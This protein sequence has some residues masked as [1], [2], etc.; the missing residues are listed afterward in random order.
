MSESIRSTDLIPQE[1]ALSKSAFPLPFLTRDDNGSFVKLL[2][3]FL[4]IYGYFKTQVQQGLEPVDGYL[5]DQTTTEVMRFQSDHFLGKDG[6]V[7]GLTWCAIAF[8]NINPNVRGALNPIANSS[9]P[10][11]LL[12]SGD[13]G[14]A[15]FV[16]QRLLLLYTSQHIPGNPMTEAGVNGCFSAN[17]KTA[18]TIF[19]KN[20]KYAKLTPDGEVGN[21]TW[22][23]LFY[24]LGQ[25]GADETVI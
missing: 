19:Q 3:R 20:Y 5:G 18:V 4:V 24:P 7:G 14:A 22:G 11:P 2:Q 1:A 9:I 12:Q 13:Q 21:Y 16:L 25:R 8:P 23:A 6:E 15:V 10:L 17:T